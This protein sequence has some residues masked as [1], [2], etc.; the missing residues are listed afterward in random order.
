MA[1]KMTQAFDNWTAY[2]DWLIKNY[3][4][5]DFLSLNE[6]ENTHKVIVEYEPKAGSDSKENEEKK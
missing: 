5:Y 2:D 3:N 6:D 1:E 4:D